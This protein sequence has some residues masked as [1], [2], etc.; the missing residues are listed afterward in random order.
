MVV[1]KIV[2]WDMKNGS[3]VGV[4]NKSIKPAHFGERLSSNLFFLVAK[5]ALAALTYL[6]YWA[7]RRILRFIVVI[8]FAEHK[9]WFWHGQFSHVLLSK[10]N[11]LAMKTHA[12][13]LSRK[14][15]FSLKTDTQNKFSLTII[16]IPLAYWSTGKRKLWK[17]GLENCQDF[18][19]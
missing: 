12:K 9:N 5:I 17:P 16:F 1:R 8:F 6:F 13:M 11:Q 2:E 15:K 3:D 14:N 10:Q 18:F 4:E 7:K 19:L